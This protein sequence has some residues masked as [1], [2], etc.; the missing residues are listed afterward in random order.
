MISIQMQ[1]ILNF[2]RTNDYEGFLRYDFN[3][4]IIYY[5]HDYFHLVKG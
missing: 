1:E 4:Y 3:S 5:E 2:V